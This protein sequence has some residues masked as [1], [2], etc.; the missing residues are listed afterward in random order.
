MQQVFV[1]AWGFVI[2]FEAQITLT[3]M[4]AMR[5]VIS[6]PFG[7]P[8]TYDF[9]AGEFNTI[10]VGGTLSYTVR[11]TDLPLPGDYQFQ[12]MARDGT[13]ETPFNPFLLTVEPRVATVA[14]P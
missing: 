5:M 9:S 12:V 3:G 10:E 2:G 6:R 13:S 4:T 14:W 1:G 8:A 7:P 11:A